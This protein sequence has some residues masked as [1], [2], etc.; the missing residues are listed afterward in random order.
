MSKKLSPN[1][2]KKIPSYGVPWAV[3]S[4]RLVGSSKYTVIRSAK[5]GKASN[6]IISHAMCDNGKPRTL[7]GDDGRNGSGNDHFAAYQ[8]KSDRCAKRSS[9]TQ[10]TSRTG[11]LNKQ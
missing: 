9:T 11:K 4:N 3:H 6:L 2:H 8:R 7:E 5:K 10:N 1:E